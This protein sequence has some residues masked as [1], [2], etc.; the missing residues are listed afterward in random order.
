M[1]EKPNLLTPLIGGVVAVVL[2]LIG[3]VSN[4]ALKVTLYVASGFAFAISVCF[5]VGILSVKKWR[6]LLVICPASLLVVW[7]VYRYEVR[8]QS[9]ANQ[10]EKTAG[11]PQIIKGEQ[12]R[13]EKNKPS[14]ESPPPVKQGQTEGRSSTEDSKKSDWP[15][16]TT[17][18]KTD[19]TGSTNHNEQ[20]EFAILINGVDTREPS[21]PVDIPPGGWH[22]NRTTLS[23]VAV[24]TGTN[25][26]RKVE[27]FMVAPADAAPEFRPEPP[28]KTIIDVSNNVHAYYFLGDAV[29]RQ[30]FSREIEL[31]IPPKKTEVFIEIGLQGDGGIHLDVT[32]YLNRS[33][34][35]IQR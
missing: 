10:T 12:G 31:G 2:A 20:Q 33:T 21:A 19:P 23:V 6:R 14:P 1:V 8:V 15:E 17:E 16:K 29:P 26:V 27:L 5:V 34:L 3:N 11:G 22:G 7:L 9:A 13:S 32:L 25:P 28:A 24:N 35:R 30:I 4:P 18:P